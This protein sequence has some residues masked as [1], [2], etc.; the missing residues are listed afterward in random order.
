M[1]RPKH[2]PKW[3]DS[4]DKR[5]DVPLSPTVYYKCFESALQRMS[6]VLS[7]DHLLHSEERDARVS[8]AAAAKDDFYSTFEYRW[9][10]R[11]HT[12]VYK[13]TQKFFTDS[14]AG[15]RMPKLAKRER[16]ES[17]A[18][19]L[20][21]CA[22]N[23]L[24]KNFWHNHVHE[25]AQQ[26]TNANFHDFTGES[27][28]A[29]DFEADNL[30]TILLALSYEQKVRTDSSNQTQPP[31][32]GLKKLFERNACNNV[33]GLRAV[34]RKSK[35]GSTHSIEEFLEREWLTRRRI[36]VQL[37]AYLVERDRAVGS[38][39][40]HF[41]GDLKRNG[42]RYGRP[43]T[44]ASVELN[45]V[46]VFLG[47]WQVDVTTLKREEITAA[48][49]SLVGKIDWDYCNVLRTKPALGHLANDLLKAKL[50]VLGVNQTVA[51]RLSLLRT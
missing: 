11:P 22:T 45:G 10:A 35:E 4:V 41:Y 36:A 6:Q 37:G 48:L 20:K 9:K 15:L 17:V 24:L 8:E 26:I 19:F 47:E 29:S 30:A 34:A 40:V 12:L 27:R 28:Y 44:R 5:E 32:P 14:Y 33:F 23:Y 25:F 46:R 2:T 1:T 16:G 42:S 39:S 31:S 38:I 49:S 3:I 7:C 50:Q 13:L 18:S 43:N 51:K 21:D